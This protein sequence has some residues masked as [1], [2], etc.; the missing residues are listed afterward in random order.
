VAISTQSAPRKPMMACASC[1][2]LSTRLAPHRCRPMTLDAA[3]ALAASGGPSF[4]RAFTLFRVK[5]PAERYDVNSSCFRAACRHTRGSTLGGRRRHY[6]P[7]W[8][9]ECL[10]GQDIVA[11]QSRTRLVAQRTHSSR[12][13]L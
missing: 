13:G 1:C 4:R 7:G 10:T 6:S 2:V 8:V 9:N 11:G 3:I 5:M 12:L